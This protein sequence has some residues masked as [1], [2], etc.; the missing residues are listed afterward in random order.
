MLCLHNKTLHCALAHIKLQITPAVH[1]FHIANGW[2]TV[3]GAICP[4]MAG[5]MP[6]MYG[7]CLS[8]CPPE[9]LASPFKP[10]NVVQKWANNPQYRDPSFLKVCI[11]I[12][13]FRDI[14]L[15]ICLSFALRILASYMA[16]TAKIS[17]LWTFLTKIL[18]S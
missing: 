6:L 1:M 11:H 9:H 8:L 13:L 10:Q 16:K 2:V 12:S 15:Y 7:P 5:N 17:N 14:I 4:Y 3:L 18:F